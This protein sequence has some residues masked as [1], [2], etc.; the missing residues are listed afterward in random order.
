MRN[1]LHVMDWTELCQRAEQERAERRARRQ[2]GPW[3]LDT[4]TLELIYT[5]NQGGSRYFVDLER[6]NTSAA[7][8]DWIFQLQKKSWT[9]V[10]DIGHLIAALQDIF[11]PQARLC[12]F[13]CSGA[14][15]EKIDATSYPRARH[16][17]RGTKQ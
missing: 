11:D 7:V 13:G 8:L 2:W 14:P 12:S 17:R 15:G 1:S 4:N 10:D 5:N 9:S 3:H 6:M 16:G